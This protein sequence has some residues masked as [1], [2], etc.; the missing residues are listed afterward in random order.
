MCL[1]NVNRAVS[2]S[3][4]CDA[5]MRQLL[6][7]QPHC[8]RIIQMLQSKLPPF[9]FYTL[10]GARAKTASNLQPSQEPIK[11]DPS[12]TVEILHIRELRDHGTQ[13]ASCSL[14]MKS[15]RHTL[16]VAARSELGGD[17]IMRNRL[18]NHRNVPK[19]IG[20]S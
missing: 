11:Y 8:F 5:T 17:A 7:H 15:H 10:S 4:A 18:A 9:G 6:P 1:G 3:D 14:E 2:V 20:L 19:L 13:R 16:D 12:V